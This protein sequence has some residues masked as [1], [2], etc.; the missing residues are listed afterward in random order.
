MKQFVTIKLA[1]LLILSFCLAS[2]S[3]KNDPAPQPPDTSTLLTAKNWSVIKIGSD[4][5]HSGKIDDA[6]LKPLP[7]GTTFYL[8]YNADGRLTTLITQAGVLTATS[9][10]WV[11]T[12]QQTI[13][14]VEIGTNAIFYWHIKTLTAT[15]FDFDQYDANN[16]V[17]TGGGKAVPR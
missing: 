15:G 9:F 1:S 12:D 6:E 2:C 17:L 14:L 8:T 10:T 3:K 5:N 7:V 16:A 13:K 11:L 4:D